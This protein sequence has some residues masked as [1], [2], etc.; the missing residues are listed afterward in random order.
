M[1]P[2][3]GRSPWL[4]VALTCLMILSFGHAQP[5]Q[6][7]VTTPIDDGYPVGSSWISLLATS[8]LGG[9][10]PGY[11]WG[12]VPA[13]FVETACKMIEQGTLSIPATVTA[14]GFTQ[15]WNLQ[16]QAVGGCDASSNSP[17]GVEMV[18]KDDTG[19]T[20]AIVCDDNAWSHGCALY[21][22]GND[23][24][25]LY[26]QG[27]YFPDQRRRRLLSSPQ[28]QLIDCGSTGAAGGAVSGLVT[29]LNCLDLGI[30][31]PFCVAG[32]VGTYALIG[33]GVDCAKAA[34][35]NCFKGNAVVIT[36]ERKRKLM[37]EVSIGDKV[38]VWSPTDQ[39]MKFS[40]VY[41]F[42]HAD[43]N[44]SSTFIQVTLV[45]YTNV[46]SSSMTK[47]LELSSLHF[48]LVI[49]EQSQGGIRYKRAKDIAINDKMWA[50]SA[51]DNEFLVYIVKEVKIA[52]VQGLY[53]P[54]TL[55]GTIIVDDVVASVHSEWF[56]DGLFDSLDITH[57]LPYAYQVILGPIRLIY[58]VLG[59]MIY[60]KL[61]SLID[62]RLDIPTFGTQ[63]GGKVSSS[64]LL[65]LTM[66]SMHAM[67]KL[68][69][70]SLRG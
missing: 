44:A 8:L 62:A 13:D 52:L 35:A 40:D 30:L 37:S 57:L 51:E 20:N 22:T 53:N 59:Q 18:F 26:S 38:G 58:F 15:N 66:I 64:I 42:G 68:Y 7:T 47:T 31:A 23:V 4:V 16:V 41:A 60:T 36:P 10:T 55:E 25:T 49:L 65:F 46:S 27:S 69:V 14:Y 33:A 9:G 21:N 70:E 12:A 67:K 34:A 28:R 63:H 54:F 50:W 1:V 2:I 11:F 24:N 17:V 29:A 3:V 19:R 43:A 6:V 39:T 32:V 61:Y 48:A 5:L 45:Q 56:L